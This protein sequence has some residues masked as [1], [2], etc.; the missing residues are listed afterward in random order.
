MVKEWNEMEI[1]QTLKVYVE[2][3]D[4]NVDQ[5]AAIGRLCQLLSRD[6]ASVKAAVLAPAKDD[7]L[8]QDA[9]P[10]RGLNKLAQALWDKYRDD[11]P[12]LIEAAKQ[13]EAS[14]LALH[15]DRRR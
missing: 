14:L 1:L 12:G 2:I 8:W 3:R 6:K 4:K 10:H 15:A 5:A 11:L 13:H 9:R 7:P